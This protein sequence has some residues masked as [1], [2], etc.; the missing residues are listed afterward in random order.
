MWRRI[1]SITVIAGL[2]LGAVSTASAQSK[3]ARI[4]QAMAA[5]P[6]SITKNA[7]IKDWPDKSGGMAVLREGSNG[8][9][10]LPSEPVNKYRNNDAACMDSNFMDLFTAV[11]S[12]KPPVLKGVGYAYM[13]TTDDWE[14]NTD[15]GATAPTANNQWHHLRG[16][17]M[18]VYPDKAMLAGLPTRPSLNGPYVMWADTPYA[19]V[20][21]PVK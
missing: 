20:M 8:W 11:V 12:Q 10:C 4:R 18:V 5:G 6:S 1:F 9:V 16:H 2:T 3:A 7:T 15:P 17:V 19:H 14:S 21:W 13:L